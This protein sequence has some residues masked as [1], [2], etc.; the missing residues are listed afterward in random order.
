MFVKV[1]EVPCNP[2]NIKF[3]SPSS[4]L[5][6]PPSLSRGPNS[7]TPANTHTGI[8][9][10][11][12]G[13]LLDSSYI[14]VSSE[15]EIWGDDESQNERFVKI[16]LLHLWE[17]ITDASHLIRL[18]KFVF[19]LYTLV[20]WLQIWLL[21]SSCLIALCAFKAHVQGVLG[22]PA[23]LPVQTSFSASCVVFIAPLSSYLTVEFKFT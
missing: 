22:E 19:T 21:G 6:M 9:S 8:I 14:L 17:D 3:Y 7:D 13:S 20:I 16:Y 10:I 12:D 15:A 4:S 23:F 11:P 2:R 5:S 1:R 18:P